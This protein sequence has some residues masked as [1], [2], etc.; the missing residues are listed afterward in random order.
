[1]TNA[2]LVAMLR[3]VRL[4]KAH[5][6]RLRTGGQYTEANMGVLVALHRAE[7]VWGIQ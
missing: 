5:A 4:H 2:M 6:R 3:A 7:R 1:M